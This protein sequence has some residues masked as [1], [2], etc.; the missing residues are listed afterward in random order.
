MQPGQSQNNEYLTGY[1]INEVS[2][3]LTRLEERI[4]DHHTDVSNRLDELRES[5]HSYKDS[6]SAKIT[7]I[8]KQVD[9][10]DKLAGVAR[11][12]VGSGGILYIIMFFQNLFK[13]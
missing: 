12:T 11:W 13:H 6:L 3:R 8:E 9:H 5:L 4:E 1:V 10:H 7:V 2:G